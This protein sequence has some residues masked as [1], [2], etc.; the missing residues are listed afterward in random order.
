MQSIHGP[1]ARSRR[2]TRESARPAQLLSLSAEDGYP[3]DEAF[4]EPRVGRPVA[5]L[6]DLQG[7]DGNF[8]PGSRRFL[9]KRTREGP[10]AYFA[11]N[12]RC[13]DLGYTRYDLAS[14]EFR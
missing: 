3:L 7:K 13:H 9:A 8:E 12:M 11:L 10:T 6:I 2:M 5:A 14:P 4:V 1:Y